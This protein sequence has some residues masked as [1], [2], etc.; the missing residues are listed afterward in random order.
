[1]NL[2]AGLSLGYGAPL[3]PSFAALS[4]SVYGGVG[5]LHGMI[6]SLPGAMGDP[7]GY[8][9][10]QQGNL[11]QIKA[12]GGDLEKLYKAQQKG[13]LP[14]GAGLQAGY[15]P[16]LKWYLSAGLQGSF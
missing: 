10:A 16:M 6:G 3:V 2:G 4:Q 9:D 12:M 8:Y 14:F 1:V 13:G 7:M 11:D 15:D 5:G